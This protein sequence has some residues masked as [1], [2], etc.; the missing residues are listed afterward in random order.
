MR[1]VVEDAKDG[2]GV[3]AH[4]CR[5]R[6][7]VAMMPAVFDPNINSYARSTALEQTI[8]QL[9]KPSLSQCSLM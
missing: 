2:V 8:F 9:C 6:L 4:N 7:K 3:L 1:V 5:R